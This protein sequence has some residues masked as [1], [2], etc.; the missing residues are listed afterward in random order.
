VTSTPRTE[1]P[2]G[3]VITWAQDEATGDYNH[4]PERWFRKVADRDAW[5]ANRWDAGE[6]NVLEGLAEYDLTDVF[7]LLDQFPPGENSWYWQGRIGRRFDHVFASRL[8]R[9]T[10]CRYFHSWRE[11]RLSDHSAIEAVFGSV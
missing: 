2:D 10:S 4:K 6:R 5:D 1:C 3:R 11:E 9:P 7:R 8:L